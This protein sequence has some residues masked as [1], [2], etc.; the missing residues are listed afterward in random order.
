MH[1]SG[2]MCK[3]KSMYKMQSMY[4]ERGYKTIKYV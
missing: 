3:V 2:D 1:K 4:K